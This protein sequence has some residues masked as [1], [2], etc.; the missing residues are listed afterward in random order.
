MAMFLPVI[1]SMTTDFTRVKFVSLGI[2][3]NEFD[4][5]NHNTLCCAAMS[6]PRGSV[7]STVSE[8]RESV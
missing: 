5:L 4:T 2:L 1:L 6:A 7:C 3:P 8:S